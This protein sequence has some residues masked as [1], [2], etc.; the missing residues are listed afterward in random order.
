M[1]ENSSQNS[2]DDTL[3]PLQLIEKLKADIEKE[4]KENADLR[5]KIEVMKKQ[6]QNMQ[7]LNEQEEEYKI[8]NMIKHMKQ[9][10]KEKEVL[11][12]R[13]KFFLIL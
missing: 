10:Q 3:N 11:A 6:Q 9:L 7:I 2:E 12:L 13:Y 8:N 4:K 1:T 5:M